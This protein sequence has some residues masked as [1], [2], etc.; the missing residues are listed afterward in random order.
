[1]YVKCLYI[2]LYIYMTLVLWFYGMPTQSQK[3]D[4]NLQSRKP[5]NLENQ[6]PHIKIKILLELLGPDK[7]DSLNPM[8]T[9]IFPENHQKRGFPQKPPK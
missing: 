4:R 9:W 7:L 1:M 2:V 8:P 6:R 5:N 3:L